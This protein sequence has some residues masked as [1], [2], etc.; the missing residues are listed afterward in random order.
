MQKCESYIKSCFGLCI[1]VRGLTFWLVP[2]PGLFLTSLLFLSWLILCIWPWHLRLTTPSAPAYC[3]DP[4]AHSEGH[5]VY[6]ILVRLCLHK[7]SYHHRP[8]GNH[9][10]GNLCFFGRSNYCH[11]L[12]GCSA[13]SHM[14]SPLITL[15]SDQ[16]CMW[17]HNNSKYVL[18]ENT[19]I[20]SIKNLKMFKI[21]KKLYI[22]RMHTWPGYWFSIQVE[23]QCT[24]APHCLKQN[25]FCNQVIQKHQLLSCVKVQVVCSLCV[26]SMFCPSC[27]LEK[28]SLYPAMWQKV[29][30]LPVITSWNPAIVDYIYI[31]I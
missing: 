2:N 17:Q 26:Y 14:G 7:E 24:R 31:Y 18:A 11:Q 3:S 27:L 15:P 20:C 1:H 25:M 5:L 30:V 12:Q 10:A 9:T 29:A 23:L 8:S 16:V 19:Y 22:Y 13:L 6:R 21:V 28:V 4:L